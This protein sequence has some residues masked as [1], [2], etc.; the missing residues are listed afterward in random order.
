MTP[1]IIAVAG[2]P[3]AGKSTL[4]RNAMQALGDADSLH[5]DDY[6]RG[7]D[8]PNIPEWAAAG[9]DPNQWISP[10]LAEDLARLKAGQ[11]VQTP[12][13]ARVVEPRR[14]ILM[15]EPFGR[16]R[17]VIAH[18]IDMVVTIDL[19]IDIALARRLLRDINTPDMT[20]SAQ[21]ARDHVDSYCRRFL[22]ESRRELILAG[23]RCALQNC[24]LVLDGTKPVAALTAELLTARDEFQSAITQRS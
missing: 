22:F 12:N 24:D 15:E 10:G 21:K 4:I 3:G 17:S 7:T 19:P 11:A 6:T 18:Y 8:Y 2:M 9:C 5:F 13:T 1:F 20:S 23:Q 14:F 16:R